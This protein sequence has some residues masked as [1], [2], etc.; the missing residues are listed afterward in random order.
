MKSIKPYPAE[1]EL[2]PIQTVNEVNFAGYHS[3]ADYLRFTFEEQLENYK[4]ICFQNESC[5]FPLPPK[6]FRKDIQSDLQYGRRCEVYPAP[7][8]VRLPRKHKII[9]RF[10]Q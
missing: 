3:Y 10:L 7:F 6:N 4:R 1:M 9:K 5:P 8:D 2:P